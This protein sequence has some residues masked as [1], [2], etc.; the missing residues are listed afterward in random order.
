MQVNLLILARTMAKAT[1]PCHAP[2]STFPHCTRM[3]VFRLTPGCSPVAVLSCGEVP[4][5]PP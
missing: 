3:A 1:R 4:N 5:L 2:L